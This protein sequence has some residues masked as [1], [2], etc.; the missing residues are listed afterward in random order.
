MNKTNNNKTNN[1]KTNNK[2]SL[3]IMQNTTYLQCFLKRAN[4]HFT[5]FQSVKVE[6]LV[7]SSGYKIYRFCISVRISVRTLYVSVRIGSYR[8]V[9]W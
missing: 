5:S 1:N 7:P 2:I 4:K 6:P 9:Y 8:F 3:K